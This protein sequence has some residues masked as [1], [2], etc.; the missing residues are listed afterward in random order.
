MRRCA[1][2]RPARDGR[3]GMSMPC[4]PRSPAANRSGFAP[5]PI[6]PGATERGSGCGSG[7]PLRP[8]GATTDPRRQ[9]TIR[10]AS[11]SCRRPVG[12]G[13]EVTL[14]SR[15]FLTA[16]EVGICLP[17]GD[18]ATI[19][20]PFQGLGREEEFDQLTAQGGRYDVIVFEGYQSLSQRCRQRLGDAVAAVAAAAEA[21]LQ[22][23][24]WRPQLAPAVQ[25]V[26]AGGQH[27][28]EGQV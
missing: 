6:S 10:G 9:A 7:C 12:V 3:T 26:Q 8:E 23:L 27:S 24:E 4:V 25:T 14:W 2:T 17:G 20:L 22:L 21:M 19:G 28:R 16:L 15:T 13:D 1:R 18:L 5:C 11:W